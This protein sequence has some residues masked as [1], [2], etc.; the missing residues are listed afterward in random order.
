MIEPLLFAVPLTPLLAAAALAWPRLRPAARACVPL[1]PIPAV[2]AAAIVEAPTSHEATWFLLGAHLGLDE[3]SR[4]FLL[5]TGLLWLL[6][7]LAATVYTRSDANRVS[8]LACFL[9]A[10][11]GNLGLLVTRDVFGFYAFFAVMSFASYGLVV[12]GREAASYFAARVYIVFVILGELALFAGL[13]LA[14]QAAQ[15]TLISDVAAAELP[16]SALTLLIMGLGVKLGVVP[17]HLW[18]PLAH[19]AAPVPASAVLSGAMI[20]AG[21]FGLLSVLPLGTLGHSSHGTGLVAVGVLSIVV[22][23]AIGVTQRNPKA[24]LAYSSVSQMGTLAIA[25]GVTLVVP[26][27]WPILGPAI[28][29]FAA[30]HAFAKGALFLGVGAMAANAGVAWRRACIAILLLPAAALAA[31]PFTSGHAAKAA[32]KDGIDLAPGA[33][34]EVLMPALAVSSFMT[35]LL[36]V[37]FLGLLARAGAGSGSRYLAVPASGAVAL[38]GALALVWPFGDTRL[39]S[40]A[41]T[42]VLASLL[43][44][45]AGLAVTLAVAAALRV[46]QLRL[47]EVPSGETLA[48]FERL[49]RHPLPSPKYRTVRPGFDNTARAFPSLPVENWPLGGVAAL[50]V[51]LAMAVLEGAHLVIFTVD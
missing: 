46:A 9:I 8:F 49:P 44:A 31:I 45:A 22:A 15:S 23:G 27:A 28:V 34:S 38:C 3:T 21:L 16:D 20:K 47:K 10:M 41:E 43:P 6:A 12:H 30:H 39:A 11:A 25:L 13:V 26:S 7:G 42:D 2:L 4:A 35:T 37:R 33:W 19:T 36:M 5:F 51:L 32:L 17:L 48:L 40:L 14:T 1:A 50:A 24:V 29:F 18:L